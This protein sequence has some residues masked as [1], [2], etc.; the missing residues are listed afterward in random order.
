MMSKESLIRYL[1]QCLFSPTKKTLVKAIDNNKLTTWPGLT[2]D[3]VCKHLPESSSATDKSH[4]KCQ[5]KGICST[6]K[7]PPTKTQKERIKYALEKMEL[8]RGINPPQED[9]KSNQIFCYNGIVNTK[10][11]TIYVDFTGK[12]PIISM[13]SMVAI[14]IVYYWI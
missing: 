5:C 13:Y 9:E 2:S 10:D 4:M 12:F 1:H 8:E 6:T 7:I 11:R 14:F 3:A